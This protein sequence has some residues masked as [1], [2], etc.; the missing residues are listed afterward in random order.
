MKLLFVGTHARELAPEALIEAMFQ[1]IGCRLEPDG[2]GTRFPVVMNR[3]S[4]GYLPAAQARTALRELADIEVGLRGLPTN[5]VVWSLYGRGRNR[6]EPLQAANALEYFVAH[7][8]R[9]LVSSLRAGLQECI[10]QRQALRLASSGGAHGQFGPGIILLL[11]G[12]TWLLLGHAL[13]PDWKLRRL[14][15]WTLGLEI[16]FWGLALVLAAPFPAL[17]NWFGRRPGAV[18]A[19]AIASVL[20]GLIGC[21]AVG[22]L[23]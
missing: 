22:L 15:I 13:V 2:R 12:S 7:D 9:P 20:C 6:G 14:P 18:A 10:D 19:L 3:L 11:T 23:H 4:S 17:R 8:G 21:A 16:V 5:K 1:T